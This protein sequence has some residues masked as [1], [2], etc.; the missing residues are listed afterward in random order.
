[1]TTDRPRPPQR[2]RPRPP[3]RRRPHAAA[4]GRLVVGGLSLSLLVGLVGAMVRGDRSAAASTV[5]GRPP[6]A[7]TS[8]GSPGAS[9]APVPVPPPI[10]VTRPS[11]PP[12]TT[13]HAT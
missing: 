3:R 5:N 8:S 12:V 9:G 1:M 13:S 10:Q 11:G 6:A 2:H 4:G 7:S